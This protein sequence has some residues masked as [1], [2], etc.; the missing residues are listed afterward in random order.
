ME[1]NTKSAILVVT[2]ERWHTTTYIGVV[3][4]KKMKRTLFYFILTFSIAGC[5]TKNH[6]LGKQTDSEYEFGTES[7]EKAIRI[8]E[9]LQSDSV[10]TELSWKNLFNTK[11][12]KNYLIYSDSTEKKRLIRYA[13]ETVFDSAN[14]HRYD[15]LMNVPLIMGQ[16]YFKLSLIRN[17]HNLKNNFDKARTFLESTDFNNLIVQG[18]SLARTFLPKRV[19]DSLPKLY[20]IHLILSDPDAK[21]MENAIVFDL[22]MAFDRGTDDLIKIIAHEFHHNYRALTAPR[23]KHPLMIQLN[24]IHQEGVADLIDKDKPP[25]QELSLYPKTIID[26]YNFDY[27][28]T[29]QKLKNLDSL[30]KVFLNQEIDSLTYYGRLENYFGFGGHTNGFYMSLIIWENKGIQVL[31]DGYD[32]PVEFIKIYNGVARE[33]SN[34]YIFSYEFI[35]FIEQIE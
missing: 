24:K 27:E 18:D 28:N 30:T 29:P 9:L 23:F 14:K 17:F 21:V 12:Y 32:D 19:Q 6:E 35:D 3:T 16:D 25:I 13:L 2:Y 8:A 5:A 26:I 20:D 15:S 11:G 10:I 33:S 31:I 4:Y 7:A 22:N 34:E 1:G